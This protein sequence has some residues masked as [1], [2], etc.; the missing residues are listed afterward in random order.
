MVSRREFLMGS[1][2][3]GI[4]TAAFAFRPGDASRKV[5]PRKTTTTLRPSTTTTTVPRTTTSI[6]SG[7]DPYAGP[8]GGNY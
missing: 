5:P 7:V 8:Y 6:Q 2:S 4:A 3:F 1:V